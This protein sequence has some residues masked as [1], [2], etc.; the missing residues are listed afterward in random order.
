M[1]ILA[2]GVGLLVATSFAL[3]QTEPVEP[4]H[5]WPVRELA[6]DPPSTETV[7]LQEVWRLDC[8]A[9]T[10]PLIGKIVAAS[11]GL[12]GRVLL[13]DRQTDHVLVVGPDGAI[14]RVA[15]QAGEGPGELNGLYRAVALADGRIGRTGGVRSPTYIFP[16]TGELVLIDPAGDPAGTWRLTGEPGSVPVC[17]VR[18]VRCARPHVLVAS[19]RPLVSADRV[20]TDLKELALVSPPDGAR[21]VLARSVRRTE[22][23]VTAVSEQD[24][25][26]PFADGRCDVHASGR[27]AFAPERDRWLVCVREPDGAGTVLQRPWA[28]VRRDEAQLEAAMKEHGV[29]RGLVLD[30]EPAL[31]RVRW[32]PD[33]RLWVEP[34]GVAPTDGALAC[35]DEVSAEGALSRR[36]RV[37][38]PDATTG[39]RLLLMEDGR[40]VVLRGFAPDSEATPVV[41]L[42]E[43]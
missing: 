40:F 22:V 31:G 36:V 27:V 34:G 19:L 35:F 42:L 29:E 4:W 26:E 14:E 28:P 5:H 10:D 38:V 39:D 3:A 24:A 16:A 1:R 32:R 8:A 11:P 33:G 12:D 2:L 6:A 9:D 23:R 21:Q 25:Y 18:E 30:H 43:A 13:V 20:F 41:I 7:V 17:M 15:G 37:V